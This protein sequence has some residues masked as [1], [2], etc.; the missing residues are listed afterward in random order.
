MKRKQSPF[1]VS[2]KILISL[3]LFKTEIGLG[4]SSRGLYEHLKTSPSSG[5]WTKYYKDDFEGYIRNPSFLVDYRIK[6]WLKNIK[7]ND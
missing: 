3:G 4:E 5:Y 2:K 1:F 7:P 6:N